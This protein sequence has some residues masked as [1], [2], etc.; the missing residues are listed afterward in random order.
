LVF[1]RIKPNLQHPA[2]AERQVKTITVTESTHCNSLLSGL[3][4]VYCSLFTSASAF[5]KCLLLTTIRRG[6]LMT[7]HGL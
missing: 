5:G 4:T 6:G 2:A 7:I 1:Y 3:M